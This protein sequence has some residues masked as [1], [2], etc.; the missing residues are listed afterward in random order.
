VNRLD[1]VAGRLAP[2]LQGDLVVLDANLRTAPDLARVGVA[3]TFVAGHSVH[4]GE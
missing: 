1:D 4:H 3:E 2:G